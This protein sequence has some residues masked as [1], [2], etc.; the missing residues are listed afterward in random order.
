MITQRFAVEFERRTVGIAVRFPGG[1]VFYASDDDFDEIDGRS[2]SRAR[3][4]E[5][6]LRKVARRKKRLVGERLAPA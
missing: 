1:F 5:R 6:Q 4:I 2:F 3:A